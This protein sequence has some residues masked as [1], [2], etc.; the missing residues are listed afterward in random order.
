MLSQD[1]VQEIEDNIK[2]AK[3]YVLDRVRYEQDV[4][5]TIDILLVDCATRIYEATIKYGTPNGKLLSF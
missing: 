1:K 4:V 5:S 2:Y 3:Y